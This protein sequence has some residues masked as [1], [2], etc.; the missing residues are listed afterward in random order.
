MTET[1]VNSVPARR[2]LAHLPLSGLHVAPINVRKHGSKDIDT[3]AASILS[4]GLLQPLLVRANADGHEVIAGQRRF[5]ALRKLSATT[6]DAEALAVVA[7]VPC[8]IMDA[9]DDAAALEASLAENTER[10]PMDELDQY[11]AFAALI[12]KGQSEQQIA[13]AFAITV[14]TVRRRLSLAKLIP[15]VQK[16]YR[17][18]EID[19]ETIK[20][21]TLASKQRQKDYAALV[22]DPKA[23]PPPHWQLK[24]WLLGGAEISVRAALF[25]IGAYTG[26][27]TTDLF[28]EDS[29]FTDAALFWELQNI[30][31]AAASDELLAKGWPAVHVVGPDEPFCEWNYEALAK[32]RGGH[33]YIE[34]TKDGNVTIHKGL[35]DHATVRRLER[36]DDGTSAAETDGGIEASGAVTDAGKR[37]EISAAMTNY[38]DCVRL[39]AVRAALIQKPDVALRLLL[40][41]LLAG[42]TSA[43]IKAHAEPMQPLTTEISVS[44]K[45]LETEQPMAEARVAAFAALDVD[46]R[47]TMI[48]T[49][50][51]RDIIA[52][53]FAKLLT[54]P[55]TDVLAH[56][57]TVM[58]ETLALGSAIVDT[59]GTHLGVSIEGTWTP[60]ATFF[61]LIRDKEV[62]NALLAEV[63][64]AAAAKRSLTATTKDQKVLIAKGLSGDGHKPA[65]VWAPRWLAF[66]QTQYTKRRLSSVAPRIA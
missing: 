55:D 60:D 27:I 23:S 63:N 50:F 64:G 54:L 39:S 37:S 8:I 3:L 10:Q 34:V 2:T 42:T 33:V 17:Q 56:L 15:A 32:T 20:L 51:D 58:A 49:H 4:I 21:L 29:Y 66:P 38:V 59:I 6:I 11:A 19:A 62:T 47:E 40:A 53:T 36:S 31:I 45:G 41:H 12:K 52:T 18:D 14:P 7:N 30:A 25:D 57:A 48:E 1:I 13:T 16:L 26:A 24:A 44:I 9:G 22:T 61:D 46:V 5:L 65:V 35:A 43:H 28:G